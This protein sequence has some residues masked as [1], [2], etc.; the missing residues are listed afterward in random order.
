MSQRTL[1]DILKESKEG[2]KILKKYKNNLDDY[3]KSELN[4]TVNNNNKN[5]E[6]AEKISKLM[7][8]D[9]RVNH[10][11][12]YKL[13]MT[14]SL[15]HDKL[16]K[17]RMTAQGTGSWKV[18]NAAQKKLDKIR[19]AREKNVNSEYKTIDKTSYS[20]GKKGS[21]WWLSRLISN[22]LFG[23]KENRLQDVAAPNDA[24]EI[25]YKYDLKNGKIGHLHGYILEPKQKSNGKVVLVYSGGGAPAAAYIKNI[26][27]TYLDAGCK[28]VVMDYRGFGKSKTE[29]QEGKELDFQL[30]ERS[31]YRDGEAMLTYVQK[32]LGYN[33]SN[34]ILHGYSLGGP[35][36][37]KV[38]ANLAERN[39]VKRKDGKLVK[40]KDRLG[41]LVLHSAMGTNYKTS[42]DCFKD[43]DSSTVTAVGAGFLS[44]LIAGAFNTISHLKRLH[45]YDP[46]LRVHLISGSAAARDHLDIIKSGIKDN[47]PYTTATTYRTDK[48]HKELNVVSNDTGLQNLIQSNRVKDNLMDHQKTMNEMQV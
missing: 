27:G 43:N 12:K 8:K 20:E 31:M 4:N 45:K 42:K 10:E 29:D 21:N 38:A 30:G 11:L 1:R 24:T 14:H 22:K 32:E 19:D 48:G 13:P 40:E 3:E 17:L 26:A 37:S 23:F 34:I 2:R 7:M 35:V 25:N 5:I 47:N 28:V 9:P 44:W 18:K 41:G 15:K 36:A 33:N 16:E 6:I 46:K 39:A